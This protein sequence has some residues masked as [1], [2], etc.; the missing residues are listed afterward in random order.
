[1]E[2]LNRMSTQLVQPFDV[3][4][5]NSAREPA[6]HAL[7]DPCAIRFSAHRMTRH[8]PDWI[9]TPRAGELLLWRFRCG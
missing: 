6:R 1:M 2:N 8:F 3:P 7:C 4:T 5:R 9:T